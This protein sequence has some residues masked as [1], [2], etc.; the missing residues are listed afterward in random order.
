[1][2]NTTQTTEAKPLTPETKARVALENVADLPRGKSLIL[3]GLNRSLFALRRDV[4][5]ECFFLRLED[6]RDTQHS[7]F[8]DNLG[9]LLEDLEYFYRSD[10][11]PFETNSWF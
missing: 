5:G 7:R 1:M 6:P 9:Q 4:A 10:A 2:M 3:R 11:L 8:C